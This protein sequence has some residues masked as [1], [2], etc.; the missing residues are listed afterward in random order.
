MIPEQIMN[1]AKAMVYEW[2]REIFKEYPPQLKKNGKTDIPCYI[3]LNDEFATAF[4]LKF[5][6]DWLKE[7]DDK[8]IVAKVIKVKREE[9]K[10]NGNTRNIPST[11]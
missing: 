10:A 7:A 2:I 6:H 1:Q 4:V 11:S 8:P 9:I 5:C 3:N